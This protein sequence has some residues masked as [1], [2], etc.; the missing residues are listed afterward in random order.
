MRKAGREGRK[1]RRERE[2]SK[3]RERGR[4]GRKER[5]GER[6]TGLSGEVAAVF[7][8]SELSTEHTHLC[9][10]FFDSRYNIPLHT[11]LAKS[12]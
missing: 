3:E 2:G 5:E 10:K 6:D 11:F 1:G 7:R 9:I 8:H 4:E 12:S